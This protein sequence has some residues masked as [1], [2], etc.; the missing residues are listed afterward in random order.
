MCCKSRRDPLKA[1]DYLAR[2]QIYLEAACFK[3]FGAAGLAESIRREGAQR[4]R[5]FVKYEE[6]AVG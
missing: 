1:K 4:W 5:L 3:W 2:P 6:D